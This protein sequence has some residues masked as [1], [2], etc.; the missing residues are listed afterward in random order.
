ML[1]W[2]RRISVDPLAC[3]AEQWHR[4]GDVVQFPIPSPP[5]Y[6]VCHPDDETAMEVAAA[7]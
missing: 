2:M 6:L 3:L 1:A 7:M 5:T 4:H